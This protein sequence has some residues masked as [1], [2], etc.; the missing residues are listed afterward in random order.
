VSVRHDPGSLPG[1]V[2]AVAVDVAPTP[3]PDGARTQRRRMRARWLVHLLLLAT[4][5]V[6]L[7]TVTA[8]T[9]G[10]PHLV[11]GSVF[12]GLVLVHV[13]Q[14]RHT[15]ARLLGNLTRACTWFHRRGRLAW[16]DLV[17]AL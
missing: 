15:V 12:V 9:E 17:L 8:M 6:S 4:F 10:W 7:A 16:S 11:V 5:A 2:V 13:V 3:Q 1:D 14:G